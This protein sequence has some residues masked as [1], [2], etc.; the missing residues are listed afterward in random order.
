MGRGGG[1]TR[2]NWLP[3][4]KRAA[5]CLG[6]DD[7]HPS[8]AARDALGHVQWLQKRHPQL[9]VTLFTTP[10]WQT[11]DPYPT[12]RLIARIP[13]V[14]D[15][16][17][18]V[19]VHP[20]GTYRLD[21]HEAFCAFLREWPAAELAMHGLHHVARG[22][23]PVLEF[24]GQDTTSCRAIIDEAAAI[25]ARARLPPPRGMSPPGWH[26][27]PALL[28]AMGQAGMTFI[29][30]ARDLDTPIGPDASAN[31][32]GL[33]GVP[34]LRPERIAHGLVHVPTNFQATSTLE[35]AMAILEC[36]GLLSLKAHLLAESGSYR[37]LDGLTPAYRNHLDRVLSVVEDRFGDTVWWTSMGEIAG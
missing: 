23:R 35:R 10:D 6:V 24:A 34:L 1:L 4:G 32:S 5:V 30:S 7:V 18:T 29:A 9:R 26:A 19:A 33:T 13:I 36:G 2:M 17:F 21:V 15:R 20:R 22:L 3:E 8:P 25:F 27:T 12:R 16:V 28:E 31:G 14:R 37:A 11:V